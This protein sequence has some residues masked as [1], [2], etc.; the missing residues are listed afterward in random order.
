M[1]TYDTLYKETKGRGG[2]QREGYRGLY[3]NMTSLGVMGVMVSWPWKPYALP[4]HQEGAGGQG[5]V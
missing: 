3:R 4:S 5:T 1:Y 2:N